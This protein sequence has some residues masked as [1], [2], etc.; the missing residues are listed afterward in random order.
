IAPGQDAA[1]AISEFWK[2][3][4]ITLQKI[5]Y[6]LKN[7]DRRIINNRPSSLM[8]KVLDLQDLY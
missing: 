3:F 2:N 6:E 5:H 1:I 4:K 7:Y 8:N